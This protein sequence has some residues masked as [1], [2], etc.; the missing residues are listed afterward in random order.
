MIRI[1]LPVVPKAVYD[2]DTHVTYVFCFVDV[3]GYT[4]FL[5][6]FI[7]VVQFLI[8]VLSFTCGSDKQVPPHSEHRPVCEPGAGL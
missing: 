2:F 3:D 1:F 7:D 4:M 6:C 5:F 8:Y